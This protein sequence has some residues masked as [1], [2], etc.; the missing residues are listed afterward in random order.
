[1]QR[2]ILFTYALATI[3]LL[4]QFA[5]DANAKGKKPKSCFDKYSECVQRCAN[6]ATAQ[7]GIKEAAHKK[8]QDLIQACDKRTCAPQLR[9]CE[10]GPKDPKFSVPE[11][12]LPKFEPDGG[13]Q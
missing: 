11:G 5:G 13:I 1:M 7:T 9:N 3:L 12:Q 8:N 2:L 6:R 4:P 10:N